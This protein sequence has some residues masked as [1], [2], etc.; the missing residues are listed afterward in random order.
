MKPLRIQTDDGTY[1]IVERQDIRTLWQVVKG[2]DGSQYGAFRDLESAI[3]YVT[4]DY[5]DGDDDVLGSCGCT[6]Y[7]LADCPIRTG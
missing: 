1:T 7:H 2:P 4:N 6:D 3:R 5:P